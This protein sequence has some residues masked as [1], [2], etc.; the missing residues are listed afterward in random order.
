MA[1]QIAIEHMKTTI[2]QVKDFIERIEKAK[3]KYSLVS[4]G[5]VVWNPVVGMPMSYEFKDLHNGKRQAIGGGVAGIMFVEYYSKEDATLLA[6]DTLCGPDKVP[7]VA[8]FINDAID[9]T[10]D[11]QNEMIANLESQLEV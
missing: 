4:H 3:I 2:A 7:A 5:Y 9:L 1:D 11:G 10:I 8:M 6:E